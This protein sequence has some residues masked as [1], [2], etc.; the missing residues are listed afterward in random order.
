MGFTEKD[1]QQDKSTYKK[2]TYTSDYEDCRLHTKTPQNV[3]TG[4]K[5]LLSKSKATHFEQL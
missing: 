2:G 3:S 4:R 5:H 1:G